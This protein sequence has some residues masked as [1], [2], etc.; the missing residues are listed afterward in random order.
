M[1]GDSHN[2]IFTPGKIPRVLYVLNDGK[3][4]YVQSCNGCNVEGE[5]VSVLYN[6]KNPDHASVNSNY[7]YTPLYYSIGAIFYLSI[8]LYFLKRRQKISHM[9]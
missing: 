4:R 5:I 1:Y 3:S 9:I 2:S 6:P 7:L 8:L